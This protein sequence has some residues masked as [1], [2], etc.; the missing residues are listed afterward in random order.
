M[1]PAAASISS[2]GANATAVASTAAVLA[3]ELPQPIASPTAGR[4]RPARRSGSAR[5]R[6]PARQPSRTA[7]SGPS[8]PPSSRSNPAPRA[9]A[10][11]AAPARSG[12]R[13]RDRRQLSTGLAQAAA[14]LGR[15]LLADPPQDLGVGGLPQ[16]GALRAAC[17]R[18]TARTGARPANR[19]RCGCRRPGRPAPPARG[20]CTPACRRPARTG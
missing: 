15:L 11:P 3:G 5:R 4:P 13:C 10:S 12:A 8:P 20:S 1:L 9:P 17:C 14:G 2:A 6:G 18:S 19:C 16:L 7:A